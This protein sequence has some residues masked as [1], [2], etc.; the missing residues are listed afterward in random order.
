VREY[1]LA[2]QDVGT[3]V[4]TVIVR[5]AGTAILRRRNPA[6]LA[7]AGGDGYVVLTK[8]WA[9]YLLQR[10]GY[11]KRKATTKAK[12]TVEDFDAVKQDFFC[13]RSRLL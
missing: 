4:N 3:V 6:L 10:M 11:T 9:W 8:D 12:N 1:V 2:L 5:S 7:S 13:L